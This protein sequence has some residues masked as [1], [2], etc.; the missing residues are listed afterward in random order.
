MDARSRELSTQVGPDEIPAS[1]LVMLECG[2]SLTYDAVTNYSRAIKGS[3]QL[4][5]P[6]SSPFVRRFPRSP[7]FGARAARPGRPA[8]RG[9]NGDRC[10]GPRGVGSPRAAARG[11]TFFE[12][13]CQSV[14]EKIAGAS[15]AAT[16]AARPG[17][18]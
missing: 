17:A 7:G 6:A 5:E 15:C 9:T 18:S 8:H 16:G 2:H 3:I 1:H 12:M 11:R 13:F 4:R 10:A 14:G